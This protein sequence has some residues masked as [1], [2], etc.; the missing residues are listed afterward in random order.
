MVHGHE[1]E[2]TPEDSGGQRS[3]VSC[4]PR[5]HKEQDMTQQQNNNVSDALEVRHVAL[6]FLH[7]LVLNQV[8]PL[9]ESINLIVLILHDKLQKTKYSEKIKMI[10][11]KTK[12]PVSFLSFTKKRNW[13]FWQVSLKRKVSLPIQKCF[14]LS[15]NYGPQTRVILP[16]QRVLT[17]VLKSLTDLEISIFLVVYSSIISS[18]KWSTK[19]SVKLHVIILRSKFNYFQRS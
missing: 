16:K 8:M 14:T 17:Q 1:F 11:T 19:I 18:D 4:S 3:L 12:N 10:S 2:Q 15:G 6:L 9:S 7:L 13:L 5:G